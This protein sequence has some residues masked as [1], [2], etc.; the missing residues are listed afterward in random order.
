MNAPELLVGIN[1]GDDAAVYQLSDDIA[2]VQTVDFFPPIVDDPYQYGAIAVANSLSDVYAMGGKP[3]IALNIVCFPVAMD[4]AILGEILRGGQDKATEAGILIVGGHTIDDA[5]PKYGLSV[6]GL[7]KPGAH[8]CNV[9]ARPG[10]VLVLTKPIG[11]GIITTAGKAATVRPKALEEAIRIMA[12]LNAAASEAM[13]EVGVNACTDVT[14]FGLLGHLLPMATGSNV[15]ATI[16][17]SSVPILP[18]AIALA[19]E[20]V[21]PGGTHRN[22]EDVSPSVDWATDIAEVER[23]L[24]SDAQTS[25]GLLISVSSDKAATLMEAL[26]QR[27]VESAVIVGEVTEAAEK[28]IRVTR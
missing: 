21:V 12:T 9:G 19:E 3:L 8:V 27:G 1:T 23:L 10:D 28:P 4:R 26:Q 16:H 20:G 24:L 15:S 11:T 14:G 7:V 22:L 25:G 18:D 2:L 13:V 17:M 5:E 6:T